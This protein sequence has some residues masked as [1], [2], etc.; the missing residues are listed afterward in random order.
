MRKWL[1]K[2]QFG[3]ESDRTRKIARA[4]IYHWRA[5]GRQRRTSEVVQQLH[6]LT[7][8]PFRCALLKDSVFLR[9]VP[10]MRRCQHLLYSRFTAGSVTLVLGVFRQVV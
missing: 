8:R 3:G 7:A 1:N 2:A 6:R 5:E 10:L 4:E 9:R